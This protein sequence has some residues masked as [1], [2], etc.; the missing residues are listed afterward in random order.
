MIDSS[1]T[2]MFIWALVVLGVAGFMLW[3]GHMLRK[4]ADDCREKR[5]WRGNEGACTV[6]KWIVRGVAGALAVAFVL[7]TFLSVSQVQSQGVALENQL[8]AQYVANQNVLSNYINGFYEQL[9][10]ANLQSQKIDKILVGAVSSQFDLRAWAANPKK[11]PLF[12][13]LGEA[14]PQVSLSQYQQI[15]NYIANGRQQF[16]QSQ[17]TLL[18]DLER[19]DVY[20]QSGFFVHPFMVSLA[21][22]PNG[23]L[24]VTVDGVTYT[25]A[26]AEA[27]MWDIVRNQQADQEFVSGV[28]NPLT[29][30]SK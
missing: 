30:P 16:Q 22:V 25:G 8:N 20:R 29:V 12:S 28:G 13:A 21:G 9:G 23:N 17:Q 18:T 6:W 15:I 27:R 3:L 2:T 10:V 26:A 14:Y 1:A 7:L 4:A 5:V 24:H 11:N 19:F